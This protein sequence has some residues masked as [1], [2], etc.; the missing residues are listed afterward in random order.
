MK[1]IN[2]P[3]KAIIL[4]HRKWIPMIGLIPNF[5]TFLI[6]MLIINLDSYIEYEM[7]DSH[8]K[9]GIKMKYLST[10]CVINL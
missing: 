5:F 9:N 4:I 10:N 6:S 1:Q 3:P 2:S 8:V 7:D